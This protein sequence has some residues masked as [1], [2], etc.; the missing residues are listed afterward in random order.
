MPADHKI[1]DIDFRRQHKINATSRS[2]L[3]EIN[4]IVVEKFPIN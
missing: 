1:P 2:N 3:Y 4:T